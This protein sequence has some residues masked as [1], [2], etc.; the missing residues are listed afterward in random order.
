MAR[1]VKIILTTREKDLADFLSQSLVHVDL[2]NGAG[3]LERRT[4]HKRYSAHAAQFG[5]G[6]TSA[7]SSLD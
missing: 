5:Q 3:T 2:L 1:S 7:N 4:F 6:I